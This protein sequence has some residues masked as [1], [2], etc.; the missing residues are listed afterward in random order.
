VYLLEWTSVSLEE[1]GAACF[2]DEEGTSGSNSLGLHRAAFTLLEIWT[3]CAFGQH[4][5]GSLFLDRT[6]RLKK[7]V[8]KCFFYSLIF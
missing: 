3:G 8:L 6:A 7:K 4:W 5:A 2:L 1:V